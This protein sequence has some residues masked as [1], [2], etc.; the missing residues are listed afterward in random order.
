MTPYHPSSSRRTCDRRGDCAGCAAL[1]KRT[2]GSDLAL[3]ELQLRYLLQRIHILLRHTHLS[4]LSRLLG[5]IRIS[6]RYHSP[7]DCICVVASLPSQHLLEASG[8]QLGQILSVGFILH[9]GGLQSCCAE[10]SQMFLE[11]D[12]LLTTS[13]SADSQYCTV[14]PYTP[15]VSR[16]VPAR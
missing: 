11:M 6:R 4:S 7:S 2:V 16:P 14:L 13:I 1:R 3:H 9:K 12:Q 15:A 5:L 10:R 8:V